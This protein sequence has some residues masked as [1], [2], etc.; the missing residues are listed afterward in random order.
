VKI[1]IEKNSLTS[2]GNKYKITIFLNVEKNEFCPRLLNTQDDAL[3]EKL[4]GLT[5]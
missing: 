5:L 3:G 1:C 4:R 2:T